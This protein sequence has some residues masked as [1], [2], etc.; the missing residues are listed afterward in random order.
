MRR[1][2]KTRL[3]LL[4][5]LVVGMATLGISDG[6]WA[7][8]Q[9]DSSIITKSFTEPIEKS[10]AASAEIGIISNTFVK[11][12]DHVKVG[13]PLAEINQAVLQESLA[14]AEA[15]AGSTARLDVAA[16]QTELLKSQLEALNSLVEGGHT[17]RFEVEQKQSEYL[18]AQAE[19]RAAKD[20]LMLSKLEVNR[21]KAQITDRTIKSPINGI[22]TE[23]HKQL[24]ENVTNSEPQY[25]TVVR[26]N[27]LKV[28]FYLDAATL[29]RSLVGD[30][31]NVYVGRDR[32]QLAG[33]IIFVSPIIDPDS[34]LGRLEIKLSNQNFNIQSGVVCFWNNQSN[35]QENLNRRQE[36]LE[37]AKRKDMSRLPSPR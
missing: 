25:A 29:K 8:H 12:G 34:G 23:I 9:I 36:I 15:R 10:V 35:G 14:I 11:E 1:S 28:R 19:H 2:T 18:Q 32:T 31:V 22:V 3:A 6:I 13:D 37:S 16:S 24:G 27:E 33:T 21:I 26:I 17:N 7:Q 4:R 20:E 30:Q 5:A